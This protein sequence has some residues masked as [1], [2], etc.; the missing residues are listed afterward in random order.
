[1]LNLEM[2][3]KSIQC[4]GAGA[5]GARITFVPTE[6]MDPRSERV[7][8]PQ[9]HSPGWHDHPD[10]LRSR[11]S[12]RGVMSQDGVSSPQYLSGNLTIGVS[13]QWSPLTSTPS[14]T[15]PLQGK[16]WINTFLKAQGPSPHL[17]GG[18]SSSGHIRWGQDQSP[19]HSPHWGCRCSLSFWSSHP[20]PPK[21]TLQ[22]P[23]K[24]KGEWR[25]ED[26]SSRPTGEGRR[27]G[28]G[29]GGL[30]AWG[31]ACAL[32]HASVQRAWILFFQLKC[33]WHK[34]MLVS[35]IQHNASI[36]V[37]VCCEMIYQQEKSLAWE[38][39]AFGKKKK[40]MRLEL[41]YQEKR[42][43]PSVHGCSYL[44]FPVFVS[45]LRSFS[46]STLSLPHV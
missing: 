6:I 38:R 32:I 1:M 12:D 2:T 10:F 18:T 4:C 11:E 35:G 33:N 16:S 25:G 30:K 9:R 13:A 36:F 40:K 28:W 42:W 8:L 44:R 45:V 20:C 23:V 14:P 7:L 31:H 26:V 17:L 24:Q 22:W 34:I 43:A 39:C 19:S 29:N 37:Y 15:F 3:Q 21:W 41:G 46:P 5:W 27:S